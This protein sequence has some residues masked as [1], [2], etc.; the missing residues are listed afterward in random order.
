M[1]D[2][3]GLAGRLLAEGKLAE[4]EAGFRNILATCKDHPQAL[5]G[6]GDCLRRRGAVA[7]AVEV[8]RR[9]VRKAP[10]DGVLRVFLGEALK[11]SNRPDEAIHQ[12]EEGL[13]LLPGNH[14]VVV[15]LAMLLIQQGRQEEGLGLLKRAYQMAPGDPIIQTNLMATL[16]QGGDPGEALAFAREF[17]RFAEI[18]PYVT[19]ALKHHML[20]AALA[21]VGDLEGAM[22][23]FQHAAQL[24]P[25]DGDAHHSM[26]LIYLTQ[27]QWREGFGLIHHRRRTRETQALG[28]PVWALREWTG[29]EDL[30][31]HRVYVACEQGAG[32]VIQMARFIPELTRRGARVVVGCNPELVELLRTLEGVSEVVPKEREVAHDLAVMTGDLPA[33]MGI[34]HGPT[35]EQQMAGV[36]Y[37]TARSDRVSHW[38]EKLTR[39]SGGGKRL[40][41]VCW[42]GNPK[43]KVNPRRALRE[44]DLKQLIA[45]IPGVAF[46]SVQKVLRPG[47]RVPRGV[48]DPMSEV[49]DFA[50]TAALLSALDRVITTDTSTAHLAGALGLTARV[51]VHSPLPHWTWGLSG[52]TC[53]WYPTLRVL[54]QVKTGDWNDPIQQVRGDL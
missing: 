16:V 36:P 34:T 22:C 14:R 24:A 27:G 5:G 25:D 29:Q 44:E 3:L 8:L 12:M 17:T 40:V 41:G 1:M 39:L 54:R 42:T 26:A 19:R 18:P 30:T 31:G 7:E 10:S 50:D 52:E 49:G 35:L 48:I 13:R 11:T 47:E 37:L 32:D 38:R 28:L 2:A 45:P 51:L 23:E 6:L 21:G 4:A 33:R 43:Q 20:A 53:P 46:V 9:A 15:N